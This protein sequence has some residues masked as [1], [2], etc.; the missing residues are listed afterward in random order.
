MQAMTGWLYRGPPIP[1]HPFPDRAGQRTSPRPTK[2]RARS[3]W[4][5]SSDTWRQAETGEG[6]EDPRR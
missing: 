5:K 3:R 2:T 6:R 4:P 1:P